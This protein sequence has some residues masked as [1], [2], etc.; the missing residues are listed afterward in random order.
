[1]KRI[2]L[3]LFS[4]SLSALARDKAPPG[5]YEAYTGFAIAAEPV[6]PAHE[7]HPSMWFSA[8]D[9]PAL[10]AKLTAD[11]FARSRWAAVLKLTDLTAALPTAPTATGPADKSDVLHKYY[12]AMSIAARAHA[13]VS[14]LAED[15]A[16]RAAHRARAIE[17]L[18]RA[19]DGPIFQLDSKQQGSAVDEIYRGSWLQ[20]YAAAYV[21]VI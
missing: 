21:A 1:M 16:V 20:N 12:G 7:I 11:A 6:L 8:A 17:L 18:L 10:K 9:I 2:F 3:V 19:Y 13:L 4:L 15:E 5:F 14:L